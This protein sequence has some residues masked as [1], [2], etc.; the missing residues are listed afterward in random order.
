MLHSRSAYALT[1]ILL[2][3][4]R[5]FKETFRT[6]MCPKIR[7]LLVLGLKQGFLVKERL[8]ERNIHAY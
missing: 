3:K 8:D 2:A 5:N 6:I 1:A 7:K 4:L